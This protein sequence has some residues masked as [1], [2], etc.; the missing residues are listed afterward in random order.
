MRPYLI[1][2]GVLCAATLVTNV[3]AVTSGE[4]YTTDAYQYGRFTARIQFAPGSGVVSSFFLWKDGSEQEGVFW[5]ELDFEKLED[6]CV[7]ETN[8]IYGNP[9]GLHSQRHDIDAE[10]CE[11][12][13]V[14]SYE[15]TP[16]YIAWTVDGVEIRRATGDVAKDY[17]D[18]TAQGM[19]LRFNVWPGDETF[20][21]V[22]N[23]SIL[24][25]YQYIDWIEYSAYENGDF[26]LLWRDDFTDNTLPA[27][28]STATW[29]SPKGLSTHSPDNVTVMD[30][31]VVVALTQDNAT[32]TA[33]ANPKATDTEEPDTTSAPDPS[34]TATSEPP[35]TS[36][37]GSSAEDASSESSSDSSASEP[38]TGEE[39]GATSASS[40]STSTGATTSTAAATSTATQSQTTA[41]MNTTSASTSSATA[42]TGTNT[43]TGSTATTTPTTTGSPQNTS[44]GTT[45]G[46]ATNDAASCACFVGRAST[47]FTGSG[48]ILSGLPLL[49]AWRRRKPLTRQ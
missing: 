30:G 35:A 46:D 18:N 15:W 44:E 38:T 5:N 27:R 4:V 31:Y 26:E 11:S 16:D 37:E 22:F 32:G 13:H 6:Q 21:G 2:P 41:P 8:T 39:S 34:S 49:L 20:G 19:Q 40:A 25:V 10:L 12:Y 14:Y 33:G 9:E 3:F 42:P 48:W 24:P 1:V 29:D 28:W 45:S 36:D 47:G 7:V 23:A 43:T 17:A